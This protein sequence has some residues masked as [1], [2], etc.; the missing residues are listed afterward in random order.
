MTWWDTCT[1][2]IDL[3]KLGWLFADTQVQKI[4]LSREILTE[5]STTNGGSRWPKDHLMADQW[6]HTGA[7]WL[8]RYYKVH[9]KMVFVQFHKIQQYISNH[10]LGHLIK[11]VQIWRPL[12]SYFH[13]KNKLICQQPTIRHTIYDRLL[14]ALSKY[15][16]NLFRNHAIAYLTKLE[17]KKVNIQSLNLFWCSGSSLKSMLIQIEKVKQVTRVD[18]QIQSIEA[19]IAS[20][21][22]QLCHTRVIPC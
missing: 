14:T 1:D 20:I 22:C 4:K 18:H 15:D 9:I 5:S 21:R 12:D 11:I 13:L 19:K 16:A 17:K 2:I 8:G 6:S 3:S 7:R 10:T